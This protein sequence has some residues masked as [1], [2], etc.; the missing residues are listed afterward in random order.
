MRKTSEKKN[1]RALRRGAL[2]LSLSLLLLSTTPRAWNGLRLRIQSLFRAQLVGKTKHLYRLKLFL[3]Y[4][5]NF[6]IV[7]NNLSVLLVLYFH[8]RIWQEIV[9]CAK[10]KHQ[11]P[12]ESFPRTRPRPR[13]R[14]GINLGLR[15]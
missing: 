9:V 4:W 7:V 2:V 12:L 13:Q 14:S 10:V 5:Y 1:E 8:Q 11:Y 6:S 3:S 15:T